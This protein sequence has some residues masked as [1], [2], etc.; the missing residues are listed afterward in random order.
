MK[1]TAAPPS[2]GG[3]GEEGI[4]K[5]D[6]NVFLRWSVTIVTGWQGE[7]MSSTLETQSFR[8]D[9]TNQ[10]GT[11]AANASSSTPA[12]LHGDPYKLPV[13]AASI[14]QPDSKIN[15]GSQTGQEWR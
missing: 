2:G 13:D 9:Y 11:K 14:N 7:G 15:K 10:N 8:C 4:K 6:V 12:R 5:P 3:H 1:S